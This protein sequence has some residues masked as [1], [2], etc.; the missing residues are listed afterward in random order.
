ML[1][2]KKQLIKKGQWHFLNF[3]IL[4]TLCSCLIELDAV[5]DTLKQ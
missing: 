4:Y 1:I 2:P 5:V 3:N